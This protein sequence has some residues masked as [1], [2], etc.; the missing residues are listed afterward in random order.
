MVEISFQREASQ[1]PTGKIFEWNTD[2]LDFVRQLYCFLRATACQ[3]SLFMHRSAEKKN[4]TRGFRPCIS[5][6][7]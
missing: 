5:N 7:K 3:L 4:Y 6:L 2:I 1:R